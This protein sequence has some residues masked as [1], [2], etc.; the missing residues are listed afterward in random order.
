MGLERAGRLADAEAVYQHLLA[1]WPDF[2]DYWYNLAIV[3]RKARRFDAALASYQQALD[4]GIAHPEEVHVN[5]GVIFSECLRRDDAA[6]AE[7]QTALGLNPA[8]VPALMNLANL[9]ESLGRRDAALA[10]YERL[11]ALDPRCY[12]ALGRYAELKTSAGSDPA[13][14]KRLRRTLGRPGLAAA[15]RATL[16][17]ALGAA[18]DKAG[19][20]D[21]AFGAYALA[22]QASR[23]SAGPGGARY[24]RKQH[25]H[26]VDQLMAAFTGEPREA[27]KHASTVRPIF[28]CGMFRSGSTLTEQVLA[29]HPRVTAGGEIDFLRKAVR[30][31]LAPFPSSLQQV[32]RERLEELAVLYLDNLS[33]LFPGA[34]YVTDKRPDNYLYIG[35]I[36]R[37]FPDARI[38]HTTRNALDNCLS[39]FFLHA[40][41]GM[42]YA[43]DLM[44]TAHYYRQYRRLMAHWKRIYG[45]DILDFDYDEFVREP[46]PAVARLLDFC[47][48]EWNEGCLSFQSQANPVK[49]ASVWQ[50][51]E[52]LY[53]RSSGRARHY[54]KQLEQV[55]E[56]L[57]DPEP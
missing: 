15:D 55:A 24:D 25:E 21:Q 48:L 22:N 33:K 23:A 42:A 27:S 45:E 8:F 19:I 36:K 5:R 37:M 31:E 14:I 41:H 32:S 44:D 3:Q 34:Q 54:A 7:L 49:T 4:R 12:E 20:H 17:F 47:G 35:L 51:R 2:P 16:G 28:I 38:V 10:L 46:R 11:L 39:I 52:P 13:L 53:Q 29:S 57:R 18:L 56:Y 30:A 9:E 50:V 40:G 6:A 43:L 26:L 1:R